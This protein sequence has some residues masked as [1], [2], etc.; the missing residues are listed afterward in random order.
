MT[1]MAMVRKL[2]AINADMTYAKSE[3]PSSIQKNGA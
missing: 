2:L 1:A 3:S